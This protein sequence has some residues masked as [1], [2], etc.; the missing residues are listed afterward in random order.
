MLRYTRVKSRRT[1]HEFDVLSHMFDPEK[2]TRVNKTQYPESPRPRRV[3][4]N[5]KRRRG[6][7]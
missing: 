5:V 6:A 3:K 4:P 1:G 7:S 2:H